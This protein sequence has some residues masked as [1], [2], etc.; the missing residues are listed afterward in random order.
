MRDKGVHEEHGRVERRV[1]TGETSY[2]RVTRSETKCTIKETKGK[3]T[4]MHAGTCY[5]AVKKCNRKTESETWIRYCRSSK[6]ETTE[7]CTWSKRTLQAWAG[8]L[9]VCPARMQGSDDRSTFYQSVV[10]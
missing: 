2:V 10:R 6:N 4:R 5:A 3:R 9:E 7:K 8:G 1:Y